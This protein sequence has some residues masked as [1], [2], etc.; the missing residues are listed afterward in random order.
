MIWEKLP[1]ENHKRFKWLCFFWIPLLL[2]I[3]VSLGAWI[4]DLLFGEQ[5]P[6]PA[7][8]YV[9]VFSGLYLLCFG[10]IYNTLKTPLSTLRRKHL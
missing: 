4:L 5:F 7:S 3:G 10:V 1:R 2:L 6:L 8:L 9:I